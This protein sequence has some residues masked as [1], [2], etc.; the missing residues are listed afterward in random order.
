MKVPPRYIRYPATPT[1]SVDAVHE[2]LIW[3][4]EAAVA[5]TPVVV[6]GGVESEETTVTFG[7]TARRVVYPFCA[8]YLKLYTPGVVGTTNL[9]VAEH[10]PVVG[11]V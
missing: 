7:L 1:L 3:E 4:D 10:R 2:R 6:E 5:V 8:K 9:S 11:G